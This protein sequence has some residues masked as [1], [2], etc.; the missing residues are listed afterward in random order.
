MPVERGPGARPVGCVA[1]LREEHLG[2]K[3]SG[4]QGE[5]PRGRAETEAL[6]ASRQLGRQRG[7]Q[8]IQAEDGGPGI[9]EGAQQRLSWGACRSAVGRKDARPRV[10]ALCLQACK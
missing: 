3:R 9:E 8:T 10:D 7:R 1:G 4:I 2:E 6:G 5:D